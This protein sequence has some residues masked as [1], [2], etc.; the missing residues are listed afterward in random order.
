MT[1]IVQL[2]KE[3]SVE[4]VC[5]ELGLASLPEG[6]D[7]CSHCGKWSFRLIKDLDDNPICRYCYELVGL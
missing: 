1:D 4:E 7:Q 5:K 2:L 6:L 3:K